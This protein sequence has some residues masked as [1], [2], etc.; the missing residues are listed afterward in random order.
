MS[1]SLA[2]KSPNKLISRFKTTTNSTIQKL[3]SSL[4][5]QNVDIGTQ[6]AA[7]SFSGGNT[8]VGARSSVVDNPE[9][10]NSPQTPN[11]YYQSD[12]TQGIR[13][14]GL[15]ATKG[16]SAEMDIKRKQEEAARQGG[17]SDAYDSGTATLTNGF[18]GT[19]P[20]GLDAEQM[21]YANQIMQVGKQR[22]F[23]DEDIRI[24][25]MTA[26]AES[27]LRNL[28]Y[29]DR[30]SVGLFQQRT[31]Q[32]WGST[33]QIM[34]PTYSAGKFFDSLKNTGG[35]TPWARAQGVQ[36]SAFADGSNYQAQWSLA[37][38]AW[39]ALAQ[40]GV[41]SPTKGANGSLNWINANNNKYHDFDGAYGAQCVDLY[42]FYMTGFVGGRSSVGQVNYAQEL[43]QTHDTGALVQIAKNQRPQM[44]DIAIWSNAMNGQGGHVA[45]VAQDNGNGTVRVLNA[46]ATSAG[47]KGNSVMSNLSTGSLLGYLRPRKLMK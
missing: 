25:L 35:N 5:S 15:A 27:G 8:A 14:I 18:T 4:S 46:N 6:Q 22:G 1:M 9:T 36:R 40:Q 13:D 45:I 47:P 19:A 17:I 39:N 11:D 29:G 42:N 24:A 21:G 37:N 31:S 7:P 32:G 43:W 23:G 2:T 12:G 41:S 30:D 16:V 28:N 20:S 10:I 44:G 3:P 33:N 34:D 38:S 26:L